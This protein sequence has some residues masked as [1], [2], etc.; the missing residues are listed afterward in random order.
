MGLDMYL[1]KKTYVKN[2]NHQ[3]PEEKHEVIVKKNG[4]VRKDID[5][6]KVSYIEEEVG[7]W[8]KA[9]MIHNWFV[10]HCQEGNDNCQQS[11]VSTE[12]LKELLELCKTVKES[13]VNSPKKTIQVES[14]WNQKGKTYVDDEVFIN[15]DVA[16]DLLPPQSGFFF[17]NTEIDNWYLQDIENT[18]EILEKALANSEH[19]EFY[20]QASW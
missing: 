4:I 19:A 6:E 10:E 20:Y 16:N 1:N 8:R 12:Q 15:T 2:W 18:I 13:L 14:G 7:Y 3:T 11:Y 9:N 17:G 5:P